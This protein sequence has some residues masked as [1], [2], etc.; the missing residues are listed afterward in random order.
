LKEKDSGIFLDKRRP[1]I[2]EEHPYQR[3]NQI[4]CLAFQ[5]LFP[6]NKS[7]E[8]EN[9]NH[10]APQKVLR[11]NTGITALR[12]REAFLQ[13]SKSLTIKRKE[14]KDKSTHCCLPCGCPK[15]QV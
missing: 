11:N 4:Q 2:Q 15:S 7:A 5:I 10:I 13:I 14:T 6:V 3:Q 8:Q 9:N 1:Q 12:V